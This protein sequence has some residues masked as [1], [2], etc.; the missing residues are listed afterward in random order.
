MNVMPAERG[1]VARRAH[2]PGGRPRR[3]G[4]RASATR[5]PEPP[6]TLRASAPTVTVIDDRP[7]VATAEDDPLVRAAVGRPR[8]GHRPAGRASAACPA[9]PT[10][11]CSP[12]RTGMPSVVYGPGGKWI[13]H[14]ADEFV[15]V[16]DLVDARRGLRR[17]RRSASCAT[18]RCATCGSDRTRPLAVRAA[19]HA[20]TSPTSRASRVGHHPRRGRGW[21]TGTT[22]V[23]P[24]P[25]TVGGVDVRGGGPGTR[26]TDAARTRVNLVHH[27][28]RRLPHRRQRL[29]ARRRRRRHGLARGARHRASTIGPDAAPRR[30]DRARRGP[31][32][33]G[34]RRGLPPP[35]RRRVRPRRRG[36]GGPAARAARVVEGTV[37]AGAG[38]VAGGVTGGIGSAS[39]VLADGITVA[40]LVALNAA[41]ARVRPWYR[42]APRAASLLPSDPTVHRPSRAEVAAA[43]P[44]PPRRRPHPPRTP[45]SGSWRPTPSSTRA[46]RQRL[47]ERGPRRPGPSRPAGPPPDRRRH[48]LRPGHRRPRARPDDRPSLGAASRQMNALLAAAAD[49]SPGPSSGV[50]LAAAAT[51]TARRT[52]ISTPRRRRSAPGR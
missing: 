15:E 32:R 29:R 2:D 9:P 1:R 50:I 48:L 35:A 37:G 20:T 45:R 22:V 34:P 46:R 51:Q 4:G 14:Q 3:A 6:A 49:S 39:L 7:A 12:S 11:P 27:G 26:E 23:L 28:R 52:G 8:R 41:G 18:D 24:P 43:R 25:G 10:A 47:A 16:A 40:A 38:A 30:A 19:G 42:H 33:P 21:L 44:M 36:R 13:A 5:G 17:G 31:V